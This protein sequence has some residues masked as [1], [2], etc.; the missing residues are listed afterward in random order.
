MS[1]IFTVAQPALLAI[2][3]AVTRMILRFWI[4][5]LRAQRRQDRAPQH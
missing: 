2:D 3:A 5:T 4:A 1:K